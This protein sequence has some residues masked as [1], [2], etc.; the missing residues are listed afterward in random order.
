MYVVFLLPANSLI[1]VPLLH[2]VDFPVPQLVRQHDARSYEIVL[3]DAIPDG[4]D[5]LAVRLD[6][7]EFPE[8]YYAFVEGREEP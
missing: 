4:S 6:S 1:A 2:S 5:R 8:R 3:E 7:T